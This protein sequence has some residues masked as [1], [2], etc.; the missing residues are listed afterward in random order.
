M[1]ILLL[2]LPL[3]LVVIFA[4]RLFHGPRTGL[5]ASGLAFFLT[6]VAGYWSITQSRASTAGIGILFLPGFGA[7]AAT[8]AWLFARFRLHP[9]ILIR[10]AAWLCIMASLAVPAL[11]VNGGFR[12]QAKN[13]E[14]DRLQAENYRKIA[15]NTTAIQHLLLVN[16]GQ[17][18]RPRDRNGEAPRRPDVSHSGPG[19]TI[20]GPSHV[21]SV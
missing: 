5:L 10:S 21:R 2:G 19:D 18:C 3:A 6:C 13:S 11:L 7:I 14:R 16:P 9:S 17:E 1:F 15:E 20:C 4:I 12:E 8:L